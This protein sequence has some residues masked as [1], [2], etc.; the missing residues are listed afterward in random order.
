MKPNF[1]VTTKG[2]NLWGALLLIIVALGLSFT[3]L[4]QG[5]GN[6]AAPAVVE[7]SFGKRVSTNNYSLPETGWGVVAN[8]PLGV[9]LG[10]RA[11]GDFVG[12]SYGGAGVGILTPQGQWSRQLAL[13]Q[14]GDTII[15]GTLV[16]PDGLGAAAIVGRPG[17]LNFAVYW[18]LTVPDDANGKVPVKAVLTNAQPRG[19]KL[20]QGKPCVFGNSGEEGFLWNPLT[21]EVEL[22]QG[23]LYHNI[24][25]VSPDGKWVGSSHDPRLAT[26][27]IG[28][29]TFTTFRAPGAEFA[30]AS[31]ISRSGKRAAG[32][33]KY[34]VVQS[35]VWED[36]E[37]KVLTRSNG[38]SPQGAVLGVT[39]TIVVGTDFIHEK[40]TGFAL[41]LPD[42]LIS[43]GISTVAGERNVGVLVDAENRR[44]LITSRRLVQI[45][46]EPAAAAA[47]PPTK[48][49]LTGDGG[50]TITWQ[51]V[52]KLLHSTDLVDWTEVLDGITVSGGGVVRTY[53]LQSL[54]VSPLY[55]MIR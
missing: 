22:T 25:D 30:S 10:R 19:V 55:F 44:F 28:G 45:G 41:S 2:W 43:K 20:V 24:W 48:I 16:S 27:G 15:N 3:G 32:G 42:Y 49:V 14:A 9:N 40:E 23:G 39:D 17:S 53:R 21:G 31:A 54:E 8:K 7:P 4:A 26:T 6:N 51:G 52:G 1:G 33:W 12:G 5:T 34:G 35:V 11:N 38:T 37:A 18:D 29:G 46:F 13:P 47:L 50:V 36:G